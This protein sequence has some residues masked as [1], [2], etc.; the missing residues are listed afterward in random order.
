MNIVI[1][2]AASKTPNGGYLRNAAGQR[3][4]FVGQPDLA[5][6]G[7]DYLYARPDDQEANTETS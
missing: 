6:A 1:Q 5:P 7:T 2:C 3:V 4:N